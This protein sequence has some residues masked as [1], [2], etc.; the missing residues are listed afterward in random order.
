MNKI[1][2]MTAALL[3]LNIGT[4]N[5][6]DSKSYSPY[7]GNERPRN[8]YFGDTHLHTNLSPDANILGNEKLTPA[9]AY[10]FARGDEVKAHNGM[11][12]RMNRPLDFLV[13]SDHAEYLGILPGLV[14]A[15]PDLL[16]TKLGKK[17]HDML[18]KGE[19]NKLKVAYDILLGANYWRIKDKKYFKSV[20]QDI[21]T[22]TADKYNDPGKFTAFIGYEFTSMPKGNNLHRVVIFKDDAKKANLIQPFSALDSE[23]PAKLWEFLEGYEKKSGG[24]V[25][26]L[27]HNGNVSNGL[28]FSDKDFNGKQLTPAYAKMRA[29]W[30]PLYEVTQIKGD[31]EAHPYLSPDDEFADYESWDKGNINAT[32]AKKDEMLKFEYAREALKLGLK[33]EVN[34]GVNPF[35]FG[36]IG[37]TDAHTSLA[38]A[39]EDNMWGKMSNK[40]PSDH[41]VTAV[42][43]PSQTGNK[44]LEVLGYEQTSSGYAAIWA[45][46]NTRKALFEAMKRRETYA[47]TGPRMTVRFFG[48]WDYASD[49]VHR[50]NFADIGYANGVP[51][52]GDLSNAPKGKSPRFIVQAAKD[53]DGANLDR[54]QVVK[55]W[56]NRDGKL[57]EKVYDVALADGRK[58]GAKAASIGS[59]VDVENATYTNTIGDPELTTVWVDPDF[60]AS[61]RAFYYVRVIEIPTPRWTAYDKKFFKIEM[62]K[63]AVMVTQERAYTSPIWYT[64]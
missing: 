20:W 44:S 18:K 42:V 2:L 43:I 55:G 31:G 36:M 5:A 25:I 11:M 16:K 22:A 48:G 41:R 24:E 15:N 47:T 21:V 45:K 50:P 33:H 38:T 12:A 32:I 4:V 3:T 10:K 8:V 28:M 23:D 39:E 40:E 61:E 13:V 37:S 6:Q 64:P 1:I 27:A 62:P 9:D 53:P 63:K 29:R 49:D 60:D 19:E 51:M 54:V 35:K 30:E 57:Q 52:G 46:E 26:A 17:W 56:L 7:A 58:P 14:S 59:T 34:L